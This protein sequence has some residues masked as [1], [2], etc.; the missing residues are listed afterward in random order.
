MMSIF[1]LPLLLAGMILSINAQ[2]NSANSCHEVEVSC[3]VRGEKVFRTKREYKQN[4]HVEGECT[5]NIGFIDFNKHTLIGIGYSAGSKTEYDCTTHYDTET[6]IYSHHT[7]IRTF[8]ILRNA[9][10][11]VHWC[12]IPKLKIDQQVEFSKVEVKRMR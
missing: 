4:Y 7:E 6:K 12:I 11:V 10:P 1:I 2:E 5:W 3:A 9:V 8:G